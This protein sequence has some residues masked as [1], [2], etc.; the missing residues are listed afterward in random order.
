[1]NIEKLRN[2][3]KTMGEYLFPIEKVTS[4]FKSINSKEDLQKFIQQRSAHVTQNTLYGYLKTRMGHKFTLMVDDE[5][6]SQSINLA[7][8][9]IYMVALADCTFYTFSYLLSKKNLKENDC[10][11]IY[12]NIISSEKSNGL[13]DEIFKKAHRMFIQR[14]EK[15]NFQKYYLDTPF[16]ESCLALYNWSPI[17]EELKTL[18]KKIVLNSMKLKWNLIDEEFKKLTKNLNFS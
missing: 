11:D 8:W 6:F 12:L 17:A 3:I 4:Y 5:V 2:V 15:V 16:E 10:K 9:N 13:S 7:K 18:D 14:Y 1:M